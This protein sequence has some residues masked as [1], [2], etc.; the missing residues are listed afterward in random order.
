RWKDPMGV[1]EAFRKACEQVR[2][3]LVLVGATATDDPESEVML[4]TIRNSIDDRIIVIT[5]ED[6][7]L[8]TALQ[9]RSAVVLQKSTR[10]GLGLTVTEAMWKGAAVIGGNVGGIRHQIQDGENGFLVDTVDEAADRIVQILQ[11]PRLRDRLG[12]RATETVR[13]NFL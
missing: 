6:P 12:T 11:D 1:I 10:A 4:D 3:N 2:C 13:K 8:L 7:V 5:P 9:R